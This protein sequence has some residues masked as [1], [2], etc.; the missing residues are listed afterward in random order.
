MENLSLSTFTLLKLDYF[1][2]NFID[3]GG[4]IR[5]EKLINFQLWHANDF[6]IDLN[7]KN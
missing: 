7:P 1:N 5:N 6:N 2:K 3:C 4:T